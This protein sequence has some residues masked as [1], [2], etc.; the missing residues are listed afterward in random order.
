MS[1]TL[2]IHQAG[3]GVT[4]QDMGRPGYLSLGLS[5][6][7]A[8]DTRALAEGAALLR[9]SPDCAVLEMTGMGGTFEVDHDTRI[10]L[11][12]APMQTAIDGDPIAWNASHLLPAGARLTI[13]AARAGVYGYLHLGGGI[14]TD[15]I[16]GARS[17]HLAAGLGARVAAGDVLPLGDDSGAETGLALPPDDRFAGGTVRVV[18]SLQTGLFAQSEIDR[19]EDTEFHRDNRGNRMGVRVVPPGEGFAPEGGRSVL[20]EIIVPG[21]IQI[22]GDGTPFVLLAE[23]QTT[24]GYPRIGA[25]LPCD[26]PRV[27][28]AA[29]GAQLRFRFVSAE[30]GLAALRREA[31]S[32]KGLAKAAHPLVRDPATIRDLLSYQLISGVTN[33]QP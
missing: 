25:V 18:P 26:L 19:F 20:S 11:T 24:G 32:R 9:Q 23:C 4:V 27:A 7:G 5:R 31:E 6:G 8:A 30:E 2:T 12:G 21:D 33:G 14:D 29:A 16:L 15:P 22:T 10:A 3:P 13:G 1:R 28:Q 17:V